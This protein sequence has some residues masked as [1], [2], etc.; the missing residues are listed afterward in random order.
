MPLDFIAS[1]VQRLANEGRHQALA[2]IEPMWYRKEC[3]QCNWEQAVESCEADG[4]SIAE[5]F[6]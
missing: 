6:N 1:E 5:I 2:M 3:S 4:H